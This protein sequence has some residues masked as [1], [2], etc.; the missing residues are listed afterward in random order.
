ME[1]GVCL[2]RGLLGNLV[3]PLTEN[4]KRYMEGCEKGASLFVGAVRGATFWGSGRIWGGGLRVWTSPHG[5]SV[6]WEF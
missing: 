1:S 4:F 6:Q 2:H 5:G 3:S